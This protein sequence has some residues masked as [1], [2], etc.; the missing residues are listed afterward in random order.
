[1]VCRQERI[2]VSDARRHAAVSCWHRSSWPDW[3]YV[4]LE[5]VGSGV[6]VQLHVIVIVV[7]VIKCFFGLPG[8]LVCWLEFGIFCFSLFYVCIV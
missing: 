1:M 8:V 7:V 2:S 4:T 5:G 6:V 3:L